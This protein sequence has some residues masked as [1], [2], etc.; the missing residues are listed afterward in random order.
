[1][2]IDK[3]KVEKIDYIYRWIDVGP[4]PPDR[5]GIVGIRPI[6]RNY[7]KSFKDLKD[8]F[9][10]VER[11]QKLSYGPDII[12]VSK[13]INGKYVPGKLIIQT[14][15]K[16]I[17]EILSGFSWVR[18]DTKHPIFDLLYKDNY[19]IR[20]YGVIGRDTF[21]EKD[22]TLEEI[23]SSGVIDNFINKDKYVQ[24]IKQN[25]ILTIFNDHH[26]RKF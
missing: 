13:L 8:V 5:G 2:Y 18:R 14:H 9:K 26:G 15:G 22:P 24:M 10:E 7:G 19:V 6:H 17:W 23:I 1:M 16:P 4:G 25:T 20:T 3:Y 12:V 11:L 21:L